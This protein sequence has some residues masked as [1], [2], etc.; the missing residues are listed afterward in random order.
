MQNQQQQTSWRDVMGGRYFTA[1]FLEDDQEMRVK[2]ANA[3]V[4]EIDPGQH[5]IVLNFNS[6]NHPL[7]VN[8]SNGV[9]ISGALETDDYKQWIGREIILY[10][11]T[12]S[13][14]GEEME[15][16]RV[17]P[18]SPDNEEVHAGALQEFEMVGG[19]RY[20]HKWQTRKPEMVRNYMRAREGLEI[21]EP[22]KLTIPALA[23]LTN[24]MLEAATSPKNG[25]PQNN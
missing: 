19:E 9:F 12:T 21:S 2:I 7:I 24:M 25:Q 3:E 14:E 16:V 22:E 18:Y 5:R 15:A 20:G 23:E 10:K 17:K 8:V 1:R 11:D 13:Y 6:R 4:K